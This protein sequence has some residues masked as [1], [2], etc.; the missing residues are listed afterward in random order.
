MP[1]NRNSLAVTDFAQ[2][3]GN[4]HL[5]AEVRIGLE[6]VREDLQGF[7]L[8]TF[9]ERTGRIAS[10]E[11]ILLL[12]SA[13]QHD[14]RKLPKRDQSRFVVEA[15]GRVELAGRLREVALRHQVSNRDHRGIGDRDRPTVPRA[16]LYKRIDADDKRDQRD[17]RNRPRFQYS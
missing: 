14:D 8:A 12:E 16:L 17:Q 13:L 11:K 5:N 1:E 4:R 6:S 9:G 7:V 2:I 15:V 3:I 10:L